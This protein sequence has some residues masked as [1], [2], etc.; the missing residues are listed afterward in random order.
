M[1]PKVINIITNVIAILLAVLEPVRSYLTT[2][3]FDW[4][5]F[6]V[7]IGGAVIGWFTGKSALAKKTV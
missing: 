1:S 2:Q 7:C 3:P 4:A 5:T 6:A